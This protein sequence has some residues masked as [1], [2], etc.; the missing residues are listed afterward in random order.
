MKIK[1]TNQQTH[2]RTCLKWTILLAI[3]RKWNMQIKMCATK[4]VEHN[5]KNL[6]VVQSWSGENVSATYYAVD[7]IDWFSSV[8]EPG[9]FKP[10]RYTWIYM[11]ILFF[12]FVLICS[13]SR[14]SLIQRNSCVVQ[15]YTFILF[16]DSSVFFSVAA[17][18]A[19]VF[20]V[21][22][23]SVV[24]S[25]CFFSLFSP[26]HRH[27]VVT[28]CLCIVAILCS[29]YTQHSSNQ[30]DSIHIS[31]CCVYIMFIYIYIYMCI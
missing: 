24:C 20:V 9:A 18:A 7:F 19:G 17:A 2:E 12:L 3:W 31:F 8:T 15:F 28:V 27:S 11:W 26:F 14:S 22:S 13:N 6:P 16:V 4:I 1:P 5:P 21:V 23:V 10:I 29:A 25:V 30:Y